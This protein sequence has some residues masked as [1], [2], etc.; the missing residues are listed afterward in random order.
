M[1]YHNVHYCVGVP[2]GDA[3][4]QCYSAVDCPAGDLVATVLTVKDCCLGQR[5]DGLYYSS[6]GEDC[7]QCIGKLKV[8]VNLGLF[9]AV[10]SG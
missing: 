7:T 6:G 5:E 2:L 9:I 10:V 3:Q 1:S 4:V 8:E